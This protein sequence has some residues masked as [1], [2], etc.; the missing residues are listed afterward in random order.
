MNWFVSEP[1]SADSVVQAGLPYLEVFCA[2]VGV[3]AILMLLIT[4]LHTIF[5]I[6]SSNSHAELH[7][8]GEAKQR[9]GRVLDAGPTKETAA[10]C[11]S[12]LVVYSLTQRGWDEILRP[13]LIAAHFVRCFSQLERLNC[14]ER[15]GVPAVDWTKRLPRSLKAARHNHRLAKLAAVA[16]GEFRGATENWLAGLNCVTFC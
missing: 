4:L 16:L 3:V 13:Y 14:H 1:V 11:A 6:R 12:R 15:L 5:A 10:G 9:V 2:L 8:F 7:R